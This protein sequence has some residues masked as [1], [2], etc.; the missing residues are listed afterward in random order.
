MYNVKSVFIA[1]DVPG[2]PELGGWRPLPKSF[3][4]NSVVLSMD[5]STITLGEAVH[6]VVFNVRYL[7]L[8]RAMRALAVRLLGN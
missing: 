1:G 4:R 7:C 2:D 3:F 6:A 8:H 5:T